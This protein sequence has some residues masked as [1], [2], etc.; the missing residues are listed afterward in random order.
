MKF[1]IMG[2]NTEEVIV[3]PPSVSQPKNENPNMPD[4][5]RS[6]S[7][8]DKHEGQVFGLYGQSSPMVFTRDGHNMWLGD[9][10]RGRSAFLILS[11]PSFETVLNSN[12]NEFN[13]PYSELLKSPGFI[14]MSVN[15][16]VSSFRTDLWV[17]NDP[18]SQFIKSVWL[19]PKIMKFCPWDN[20]KKTIFDSTKWEMLDITPGDCPNTFFFRRNDKFN[21]DTFMYEDT[22]NWGSSKDFGGKR[23]VMLI[24]IRMLYYLGIRNIFLLG[25]DFKMTKDYTYHFSQ[26]RHDSSI[27]SNNSTYEVLIE[28]FNQLN[29]HFEKLGLKVYNCNPES[30]LTSFKKIDIDTAI[31]MST[32]GFPNV[33]AERTSGLYDREY[34]LRQSSKEKPQLT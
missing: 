15:N 6:V 2:E 13:K 17:S 24:A 29:P 28:R 20:E 26:K 7:G 32:E 3:I 33:A 19:D 4:I 18:P 34:L 31:K 16:A 12:S 9:M 14:T 25:C 23:S 10:Y 22:F 5:L 27:K 8:R 11:G 30:N 21:A 1:T